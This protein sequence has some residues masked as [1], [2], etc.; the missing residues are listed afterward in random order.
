MPKTPDELAQDFLA[1]LNE[2]VRKD[3]H[4]RLTGLLVYKLQQ[5]FPGGPPKGESGGW[6]VPPLDVLDCVLSLNRSYDKFCLPKVQQFQKRHPELDSLAGLLKLIRSY[7]SPLE[8][9]VHEL[10]YRDEARASVLVQVIEYLLQE[11]TGFDGSSE[12]DRLTQWANKV[13]PSDYEAPKIRGF[14]LSGFQYL[15]I[16]FGAQAVKPDVHIRR[17]VSTALESLGVTDSL[18]DVEVLALMEDAG[19]DLGWSLAD[20]DFAIWKALA[21][22]KSPEKE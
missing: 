19:K 4:T 13:K 16:L 14:K 17:F 20:L 1:N 12:T 9:S 15:R 11:Q 18:T 6:H 3:H 21:R 22:D 2:N 8:F 7:P 10:N 5:S